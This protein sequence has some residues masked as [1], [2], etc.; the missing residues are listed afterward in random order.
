M[1]VDTFDL[2]IG[3]IFAFNMSAVTSYMCNLE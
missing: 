2:S 1:E 3:F